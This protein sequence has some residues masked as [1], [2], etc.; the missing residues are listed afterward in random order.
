[1]DVRV[2]LKGAGRLPLFISYWTSHTKAAANTVRSYDRN[3]DN[4]IRQRTDFQHRKAGIRPQTHRFNSGT[5]YGN[6]PSQM[7][8]WARMTK[9]T[10]PKAQV[11]ERKGSNACQTVKLHENRQCH[12]TT[13]VLF[14]PPLL[15]YPPNDKRSVDP[16]RR[17]GAA[18]TMITGGTSAAH[19]CPGFGF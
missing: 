15:I 2:V 18:Q 3:G 7:K 4:L 11:N 16:R 10:A 6:Q 12:P 17:T 14:M 19:F 9:V 5:P 8:P 1:M 13:I